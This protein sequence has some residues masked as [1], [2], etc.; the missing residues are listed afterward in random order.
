MRSES[1][2]PL[3]AVE[4]LLQPFLP[5]P[6]LIALCVFNYC[7]FFLCCYLTNLATPKSKVP[8]FRLYKPYQLNPLCPWS[9]SELP[10]ICTINDLRY[11][12]T[13]ECITSNP[14]GK[15]PR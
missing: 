6:D 9:S 12:M 13:Q 2:S 15:V 14:R 7:R 1:S 11:I 5:I 10:A 8:H 3:L 4:L